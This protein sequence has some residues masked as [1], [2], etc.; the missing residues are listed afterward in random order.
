MKLLHNRER[1]LKSVLLE[2]GIR[3]CLYS[4]IDQMNRIL[5]EDLHENNEN[6]KPPLASI[7]VSIV[8]GVEVEP[9]GCTVGDFS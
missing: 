9:D 4:I 8:P 2:L 5:L 6:N 7:A 3:D 1:K